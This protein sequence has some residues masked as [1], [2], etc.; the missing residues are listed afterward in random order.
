LLDKRNSESRTRLRESSCVTGGTPD[1]ATKQTIETLL[2]FNATPYAN[3]YHSNNAW[4]LMGPVHG[5][6]AIETV[7]CDLRMKILKA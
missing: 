5:L 2:F 7:H 6:A 4:Q 3:N 1:V